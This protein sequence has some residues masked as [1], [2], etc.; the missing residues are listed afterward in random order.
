MT[1]YQ[2]TQK[3]NTGAILILAVILIA[4]IVGA[5]VFG[6]TGLNNQ[7]TIAHPVNVEINGAPAANQTTI[8][9]GNMTW[10]NVYAKNLTVTNISNR[11]LTATL[12]TDE[13]NGTIHTWPA[14]NT[15]LAANQTATGLLSL[16]VTDPAPGDYNWTISVVTVYFD[17]NSTIIVTPTETPAPT[18]PPIIVP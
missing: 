18:E 8:Y 7:G 3:S 9:W 1:T 16:T 5:L 17:S 14:N 12:Y 2:P 10:G 15:L 6:Q 11:T 4:V 13:P